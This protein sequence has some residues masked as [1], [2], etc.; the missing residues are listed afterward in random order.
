MSN[1]GFEHALKA[2][3]VPFARA[4]VGDRY[5]MEKLTEEGLLYGAE[6]SGHILCLDK[7]ST[8]DGIVSALQVLSVMVKRK[9]GL[10]A[11]K[12]GFIRYPQE[13][14]NVRLARKLKVI[15]DEQVLAEIKA[16]EEQIGEHGRILIRLSG[17]EPLI[18][19]M[20]EGRD[21][22][23]VKQLVHHLEEVVANT[24]GSQ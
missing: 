10:N 5:V 1:L 6:P 16:A 24:Y 14:V 17:T 23:Q 19:I 7:I 15:D 8:G 22:V 12:Q 11:L 20:V 18:R 3:N 4:N 13:L 2:L 21:A 9:V